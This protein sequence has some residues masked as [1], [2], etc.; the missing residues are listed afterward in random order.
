MNKLVI[1]CWSQRYFKRLAYSSLRV[2]PNKNRR[3]R[4]DQRRSDPA[5]LSRKSAMPLVHKHFLWLMQALFARSFMGVRIP[6]KSA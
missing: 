1:T 2:K 3:L 4:K 5:C 6:A